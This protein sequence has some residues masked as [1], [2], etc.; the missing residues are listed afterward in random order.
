MK[1]HA[2]PFDSVTDEMLHG[3][4]MG[5]EACAVEC[6]QFGAVMIGLSKPMSPE[7]RGRIRYGLA[8]LVAPRATDPS[9]AAF[10]SETQKDSSGNY[11]TLDSLRAQGLPLGHLGSYEIKGTANLERFAI[12]S[13]DTS[14]CELRIQYFW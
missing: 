10:F 7:F 1:L 2:P 11:Y 14:V 12:C 13:A 5:G 8:C 3:L 4:A 6:V 9:L